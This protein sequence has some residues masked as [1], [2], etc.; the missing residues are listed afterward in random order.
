MWA[1]SEKCG[2]KSCCNDNILPVFTEH[3]D[4]SSSAHIFEILTTFFR[5]A[6]FRNIE[7]IGRAFV[8]YCNA[9]GEISISEETAAQLRVAVKSSYNIFRQ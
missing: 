2:Q 3:E 9:T 4:Y 1:E 7:W 5:K 8:L 6:L